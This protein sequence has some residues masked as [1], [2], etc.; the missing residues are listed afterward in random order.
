MN[1]INQMAKVI[2]QFLIEGKESAIQKV[3]EE[4]NKRW[5]ITCFSKKPNIIQMWSHY[6]DKHKGIVIGLE[7]GEITGD[8]PTITVEY[9][10]EKILF[11]YTA[12]IPI[13][14]EIE[15]EYEEK[16]LK[17]M[18]RKER[19]WCYEREVR[20]YGG[21]D[22]AASDRN[23]YIDIPSHSIK[24]LYLGLNSTE[25]T[26]EK[27]KKMKRRRKYNHLKI[28]RMKRSQKAYKLIPNEIRD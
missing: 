7:E 27:A 12:S 2:A 1:S 4:M 26:L 28:F 3:R 14:P 6:A 25:D 5:G 21:L 11:P 8:V 19:N 23:F 15:K 20:I 24:K 22:E 17:V 9:H 13:S 10:N 18:G 16:F